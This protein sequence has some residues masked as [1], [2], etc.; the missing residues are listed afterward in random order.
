MNSIAQT[1]R[2]RVVRLLLLASPNVGS[3]EWHHVHNTFYILK[4]NEFFGSH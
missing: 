2:T 4:K 1:A 3:L